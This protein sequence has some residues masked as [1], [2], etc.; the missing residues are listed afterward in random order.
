LENG[1]FTIPELDDTVAT[2]DI[3]ITDKLKVRVYQPLDSTLTET[4]PLAIY[5]HG[6]GWALGDLQ[7]DDAL[8]RFISRSGPVV[9]LSV[10]YRLAPEYPFPSALEDCLEVVQ[11]AL[12]HAAEFN[13]NSARFL[14][15]GQSAGGNLAIATALKC[16][17]IGITQLAGVVALVPITCH[18]DHCPEE[19]VKQYT[20]YEE[21]AYTPLT[22]AATMRSLYGK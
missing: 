11:W 18:P 10:D 19:L 4:L 22:A 21:N 5:T 3:S 8:C 7:V 13:A 2:R 14:T 1:K 17:D 6:G 9:V 16:L 15:V 12:Q 20:S